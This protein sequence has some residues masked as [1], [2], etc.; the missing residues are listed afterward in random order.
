[1]DTGWLKSVSNLL[2]EKKMTEILDY[3][4]MFALF[5]TKRYLFILDCIL[6]QLDDTKNCSFLI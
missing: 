1:M 2:F 3:D 6:L 4:E 5:K